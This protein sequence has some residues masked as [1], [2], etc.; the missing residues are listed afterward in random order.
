MLVPAELVRLASPWGKL[1]SN[2]KGLEIFV[3]FIHVGGLL[4]GGGL[5]LSSDRATLRAIRQAVHDRT[6]HLEALSSVHQIV[7]AGLT[8]TFISGA[9]LFFSDVTTF[10]G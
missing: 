2:S 5:A 6:Q 8:L 9:L 1:Y 10:W 3:T 7:L 4:L